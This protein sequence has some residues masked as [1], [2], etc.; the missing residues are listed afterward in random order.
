MVFQNQFSVDPQCL[1]PVPLTLKWSFACFLREILICAVCDSSV[2]RV[3]QL[4]DQQVLTYGIL[5]LFFS[6]TPNFLGRV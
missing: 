1:H 2:A 3:H 4:L 6:V 5:F